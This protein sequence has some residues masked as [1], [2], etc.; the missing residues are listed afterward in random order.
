MSPG[1]K[2]PRRK[3]DGQSTARKA[4]LRA[5]V[6]SA[7]A[8]SAPGSPRATA[9]R[10]TWCG[11]ARLLTSRA[12]RAAVQAALLHGGRPNIEVRVVVVDD[13][14]LCDLHGRFLGDPAPTD[15]IAFDL[16]EDGGP[17]GEIYASAECAARVARQRG[18]EPG[19]ELALYLV[20]GALHLCG[21][22]DRAPQ[23]RRR[24]RAT[25]AQVLRGLGYEA[26]PGPHP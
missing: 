18:V 14:A 10:I 16:G 8:V 2:K 9:V 22:D 26:D 5:P 23:D 13:A 24:M 25:E 20:H 17:A 7:K 15:V 3:K 6:K 1:R 4:A 21:L 11:G 19:R 12:A